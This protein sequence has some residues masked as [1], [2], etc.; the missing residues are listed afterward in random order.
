[1]YFIH[2]KKLLTFS[3]LHHTWIPRIFK[4]LSFNVNLGCYFQHTVPFTVQN[5]PT[6]INSQ[7]FNNFLPKYRD[8]NL[9]IYCKHSLLKFVFYLLSNILFH[10]Y[11][12]ILFCIFE[13]WI[14]K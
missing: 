8:M 11:I 5:T 9:N 7:H 14:F 10:E 12:F 6:D 3:M 1:M 13:H 2:N 4:Q